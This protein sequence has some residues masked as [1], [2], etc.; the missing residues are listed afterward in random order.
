MGSARMRMFFLLFLAAVAI[1]PAGSG[2]EERREE[3][4]VRGLRGQP[5][6]ATFRHYAGDVKLQ[7]P[8]EHK[9]LFYWFFEAQT[10]VARKPLVLWLNGGLSLSPT[11]SSYR[12]Y[13]PQLAEVIY[14]KN[15]GGRGSFINLKGFMIGNAVIN[16]P[17]DFKGLIDYAW[18]HAV[19]SDQLRDGI[20]KE[21]DFSSSNGTE[22]PLCSSLIRDFLVAYSDID[23]PVCDL[24]DSSPS[25]RLFVSIYTPVC[26]LHDSSPSHRLFVSPRLLAGHELWRVLPSGYDPC[27]EEYVME[28][29][30]RKDVQIA[31]HANLTG[32]PYPYTTCSILGRGLRIR[33]YSGDTDGR[34]PVTSTRYSVNE[35]KMRVEEEWR[36]WF[37]KRQVAG[38][39]ERYQGGLTLATVRGAGHQVPVFAPDQS[40]SLFTHFL[41]TDALPY[42]RG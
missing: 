4:R 34:V 31:L 3:D 19:I 24:H 40:L 12:H 16:D 1:T 10:D 35:M 6:G 23:I 18:S 21:C 28:F 2:D 41:A 38:W 13:V 32:L 37:H 33:I 14:D 27:T 39:V 25:H 15:K 11:F 17:T 7:H 29:F 26:D 42:S 22:T 5:A 20:F 36:A 8:N 30:N 9:A